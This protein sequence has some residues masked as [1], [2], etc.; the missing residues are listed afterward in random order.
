MAAWALMV[1]GIIMLVLGWMDV[2]Q[3][4]KA[5]DWPAVGGTIESAKITS[6]IKQ[7]GGKQMFEPVIRYLYYVDG[8]AYRSEHIR[9]GGYP[10]TKREDAEALL[11]QYPA[12]KMVTV[13][14]DPE[15]PHK[16]VLDTSASRESVITICLGILFGLFGVVSLYN[17]RKKKG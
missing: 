3:S 6:S 16:A 12:D 8:E 11:A 4:L 1:G 7:I 13:H 14:F 10:F 9:F 15:R 17:S 2:S 5:Q